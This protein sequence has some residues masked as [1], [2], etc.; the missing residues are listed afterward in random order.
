M[1]IALLFPRNFNLV[2]CGSSTGTRVGHHFSSDLG[3]AWMISLDFMSTLLIVQLNLTSILHYDCHSCIVQSISH[4][5][6]VLLGSTCAF[7]Q[8]SYLEICNEYNCYNIISLVAFGKF[9]G[10]RP[11][12]F[13][14]KCLLFENLKSRI[15]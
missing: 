6:L 12:Y 11:S 13:E 14:F 10:F 9:E 7:R 2:C 3:L 15:I 1:L 5:D 4:L 8:P